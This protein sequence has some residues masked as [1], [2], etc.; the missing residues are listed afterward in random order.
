MTRSTISNSTVK[1]PFIARGG[2]VDANNLVMNYSALTNNTTDCGAA[3]CVNFYGGGAWVQGSSSAP[4]TIANSTISG[5]HASYGGAVLIKRGYS[6][7]IYNSTISGNS[8]FLV[9]GGMLIN[10]GTGGSVVVASSTFASNTTAMH[11]RGLASVRCR[12]HHANRKFDLCRQHGIRRHAERPRDRR[13][14]TMNMQDK[15][16][17]FNLQE[18][19]NGILTHSDSER[20]ICTRGENTGS[21]IQKTSCKTYGDIQREKLALKAATDQ[22]LRDTPQGNLEPCLHPSMCGH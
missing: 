16:T 12:S 20:L 13:V 9:D 3:I 6:V 11:P 4:I 1:A 19:L 5:N 2:G 18:H 21:H 7:H 22:R 14:S 10:S 17:L 8:A 15:L